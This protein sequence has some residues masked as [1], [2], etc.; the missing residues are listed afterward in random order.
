MPKK[1]ATRR[2]KRTDKTIAAKN[3]WDRR[4]IPSLQLHES[5]RLLVGTLI[6]LLLLLPWAI[7]S[8]HVAT[9]GVACF[10]ALVALAAA[11]LPR[12]GNTHSITIGGQ[13]KR[14]LAFPFFWIGAVLLIYVAI[15]GANTAWK[16]E[17]TEEFRLLSESDH[18]S[19]LPAGVTGGS[20]NPFHW[21]LIFGTPFLAVCAAWVG[22]TRRKSILLLLSA[23]AVSGFFIAALAFF[24]IAKNKSLIL[25]FY[26]PPTRT[27]LATF[28]FHW[29][30]AAYL[31][32]TMAIA[33]GLAAHHYAQA[34]RTFK[35]SNPSGLFVFVGLVIM[36]ITLFSFSNVSAAIACGIMAAFLAHIGYRELTAEAPTSRKVLLAAVALVVVGAGAQLGNNTADNYTHR[37]ERSPDTIAAIAA[38]GDWATS[39]AIGATMFQERTLFGWG[40]GSFPSVYSEVARNNDIEDAPSSLMREGAASDWFR[41]PA[42]LGLVGCLL[43]FLIPAS[44]ARHY[45]DIRTLENPLV[46]FL[47]IGTLAGL[48]L[49]I[50]STVFHNLAFITTWSLIFAL[51]AILIRVE[52]SLRSR[53]E[54]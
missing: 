5:E 7:G 50:N 46:A 16:V 4:H 3:D 2:S 40:A 37:G 39:R 52:R 53:S 49:A 21:L 51:G 18:I 8:T 36:L 19:W 27:F 15:Q 29:E 31:T 33:V 22:I 10:V 47:L 9:Q 34:R 17:G 11:L 6:F 43:L 14:L 44:L 54:D 24:S 13:V 28:P 23:L 45:F 32:L 1:T 35:R 26:E 12:H 48:L 41:F 38:S 42:E 30:G 20:S 25:W